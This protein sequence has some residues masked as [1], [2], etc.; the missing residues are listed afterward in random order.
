MNGPERWQPSCRDR[1]PAD[2][3]DGRRLVGPV[4]RIVRMLG[5]WLALT[6]GGTSAASAAPDLWSWPTAAEQQ[7]HPAVVRIVTQDANGMS[8][9]SGTL[10]DVRDRYGLVVTNW[11]VVRD[12]RGA[13]HVVFPDGFR[14][15]AEVLKTDR[16]WDLA[17]LVIWRPAAEPLP[18]AERGADD[19][20]LWQRLVSFRLGPLH[21]IPG[22]QPASSI[23]AGRAVGC[24]SSRRLGRTDHQPAGAAG[25]GVVRFCGRHH[26]GKLCSASAAVSGG[27]LA[28]SATA[29]S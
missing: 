3:T 25:G 9:G 20:R 16:H 27:G 24:G 13:I 14:S 23:R 5:L 18:L 2:P 19:S 6:G 15:A 11:H 26:L 10:V 29:L 22:S 12:A 1:W 7:P 4:A 21:A 28:A 8:L 17:A